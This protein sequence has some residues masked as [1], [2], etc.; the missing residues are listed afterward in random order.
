MGSGVVNIVGFLLSFVREVFK[1]SFSDLEFNFI[2]IIVNVSRDSSMNLIQGALLLDLSLQ[3]F[4]SSKVVSIISLVFIYLGVFNI[5]SVIDLI[6][7]L[8]LTF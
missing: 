3:V 1:V 8:I 6:G 2:G 4:Q 7:N 5:R